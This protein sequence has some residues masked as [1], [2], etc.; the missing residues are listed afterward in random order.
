MQ[1]ANIE[2]YLKK[3]VEQKGGLCLKFISPSM[4]GA[5]D[6]IVMLP[7]RRI[8]FVE[9]KAPKKKPRPEQLRVHKI[10]ENL[11][12]TVY[13]ANTKEKVRDILKN[14]IR[15]AQVPTDGD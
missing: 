15:T 2:K 8:F 14:E 11:G 6:R 5:P 10:F 9:L 3:C 7:Q 12:V 13:T 1:E 4:R